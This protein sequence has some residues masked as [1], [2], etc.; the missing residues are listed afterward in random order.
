[1]FLKGHLQK[2]FSAP[3]QKKLAM[4]NLEDNIHKNWKQLLQQLFDR[5][6]WHICLKNTIVFNVTCQRR[7]RK[8]MNAVKRTKQV[9][10]VVS[11]RNYM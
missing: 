5:R 8:P 1:M 7:Y 10:W 11:G 6:Y 9:G 3:E 2:S 4:A